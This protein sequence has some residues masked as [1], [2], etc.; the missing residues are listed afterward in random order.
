MSSAGSVSSASPR[1]PAATTPRVLVRVIIG[2]HS[3]KLLCPT[4]AGHTHRWTVFVKPTGNLQFTDRSFIKRVTFMLHES[5]EQPKR[6]IKDPPFQVT[7]TGYGGFTMPIQIQ[8]NGVLKPFMINYE[9]ALSLDR[10]NEDSFEQKIEL[11]NPPREICELVHKY[12]PKRKDPK[13]ISEKP[14]DKATQNTSNS[15][16]RQ[17]KPEPKHST[18]DE[19]KSKT[20]PHSDHGSSSAPKITISPPASSQSMKQQLSDDK[21]RDTVK[22]KNETDEIVAPVKIKKEK[23]IPSASPDAVKSKALEEPKKETKEKPSEEENQPK[24]KDKDKSKKKKKD[25]DRDKEREKHG[26]DSHKEKHKEKKKHRHESD[27]NSTT[28][29]KSHSKDL[30]SPKT[31]EPKQKEKSNRPQSP[32]EP[33]SPCHRT[34][35]IKKRPHSSLAHSTTSLVPPGNNAEANSPHPS[36]LN[37]APCT[38]CSGSTSEVLNEVVEDNDE[39]S[40]QES[41]MEVKQAT[42]ITPEHISEES[43]LDHD[44]VEEHARY[45]VRLQNL[46]DKLH[47]IDDTELLYRCAD[48]L[49]EHDA[50]V[51]NIDKHGLMDFD[52]CQVKAETV[53][54]LEQVFTSF[55]STSKH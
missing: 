55:N 41:P 7:E 22:R 20:T 44:D 1:F 10:F 48:T 37:S 46:M 25:K 23:L 8:F 27:P 54:R 2:H 3:E 50:S 40:Q 53:S 35:E 47:N 28:H 4:P 38:P 51:I 39:N 18:K 31:E 24:H 36:L 6:A 32:T 12:C 21:K 11:K 49:I 19:H 15:E 29:N 43:G 9:L 26:D 14:P 45:D 42:F 52:L 17:L 16:K 13:E 30:Q 34:S 33:N 5:F